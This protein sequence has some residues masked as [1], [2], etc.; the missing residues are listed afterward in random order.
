MILTEKDFALKTDAEIE[1]EIEAKMGD[2]TEEQRS[3]IDWIENDIRDQGKRNSFVEQFV[4][5]KCFFCGEKLTIPALMWHG[6]SSDSKGFPMCLHLDC[7]EDFANR[8]VI[9]VKR[10]RDSEK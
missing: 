5:D 7:V 10:F 3:S 4:K 6:N 2:L 9:D 8:I 1:A